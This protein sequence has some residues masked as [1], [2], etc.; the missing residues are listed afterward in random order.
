[1]VD[2]SNEKRGR[3]NERERER[4]RRGAS[5]ISETLALLPANGLN[6]GNQK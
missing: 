4:E 5:W 1:M 6:R 2:V 3:K